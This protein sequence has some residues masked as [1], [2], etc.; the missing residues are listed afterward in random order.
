MA[1]SE[2]CLLPR[3]GMDNFCSRSLSPAIMEDPAYSVL[4][5][6]RGGTRKQGA[7]S[8]VPWGVTMGVASSPEP[9]W[10]KMRC[11]LV[12]LKN[13][14]STSREISSLPPL[15]SKA[16][17]KVQRHIGVSTFTG[18]PTSGSTSRMQALGKRVDSQPVENMF[19]SEKTCC[20]LK[21]EN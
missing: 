13:S 6:P 3:M 4:S 1:E 7:S 8:R 11:S 14:C 10:T 2:S 12:R 18:S 21:K 20:F 17:Q 5:T 19:P 15:S 16:L 9:S